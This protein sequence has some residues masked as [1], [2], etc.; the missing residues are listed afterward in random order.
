MSLL[1]RCPACTTLYRVVPDQLRISQGWV[2]CGQCGD[3]FDA[4]QHLIQASTASEEASV[5][6]SGELPVTPPVEG[7][8]DIASQAP[9]EL[10]GTGDQNCDSSVLE[11]DFDLGPEQIL[12]SDPKP[13][14]A[15]ESQA[16]ADSSCQT[17]IEPDSLDQVATSMISESAVTSDL[18]NFR[19][20][21]EMTANDKDELD[22]VSF[23]RGGDRK[24]FWHKPVAR[25]IL[26]LIVVILGLSLVAQWVYRE[27]DH[28]AAARPELA[29]M[30]E[31]M[32]EF[33]HCSVQ[34]FVQIE[35]LVIDSAG[36]KKLSVDSYRLSFTL[37]N[38]A[39]LTLALPSIELTLTDS[40]DRAVVRRVLS[41]EE[42]FATSDRL[43]AGAEW[44][45][46]VA[47][48]VRTE[49]AAPTVLGYRLLAFYP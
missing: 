48:R 19:L 11:S 12:E 5:D 9:A 36:F 10:S 1:T 42:L 16:E 24:S 25:G 39:S 20:A 8:T 6:S 17:D 14:L 41:P 7:N 28:L 18:L 35:S 3:I 31:S 15:P 29:P 46:T 38:L 47:V 44:P 30:L 21:E 23:L 22:R 49:A 13:D 26:S 33:L 4:S 40:Q 34:A 2:K 43:P 27:R 37:R 45:V 32:C